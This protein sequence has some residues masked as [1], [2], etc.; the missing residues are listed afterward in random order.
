MVFSGILKLF[1]LKIK[2]TQ[3]K[4]AVI[5]GMSYILFIYQKLSDFVNHC[6]YLSI[7]CFIT[8]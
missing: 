2:D 1:L 6:S 5:G 8:L 7:G 4:I 3:F